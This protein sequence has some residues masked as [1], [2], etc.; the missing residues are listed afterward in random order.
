[1]RLNRRF[2]AVILT[3]C[4]V[5][6]LSLP[7]SAALEATYGE[8]SYYDIATTTYSR[9]LMFQNGVVPAADENKL[10]GLIDVTGK[11]VVPF[12]YAGMWS[13]G[14]GYFK[15]SDTGYNWGGNQ[16]IIDS[17]GKVVRAMSEC[18]IYTN[19]DTI[20]IDSG[21]WQNRKH[22]CF[23]FS[24]NP[25]AHNEAQESSSVPSALAGYDY[26][27][28]SGKYYFVTNYTDG[29]SQS[30]LLDA[31]YNVVF[32][33]GQYTYVDVITTSE[34]T[35]F[36]AGTEN[37]KTLLNEQKETIIAAG[38]YDSMERNRYSDD[39]LAV[40]S[41]DKVGAISITGKVL[42]PLGEYD[43]ITG[44]NKDGYI[45]AVSYDGSPWGGELTNIVSKVFKDG[46]EVKTFDG[47]RVAT[48]VY[49]RD[50][51]FSTT[52]E[53]NG[54]MDMNGKVILE[55]KYASIVG[56]YENGAYTGDLITRLDDEENWRYVYGMYTAD[57]K[58]I[59]AD[60]YTE[61][62]HLTDGKYRL[63]DGEHY[64]IMSKS[65]ATVIPFNYVDMRVHTLY[66]I[67]LYDG[68][69]Y[70]IVDV[71]NNTIIG[72]SSEEIDLFKSEAYYSL[73]DAL[74]QARREAPEYDGYSENVYPFCYKTAEGYKTAYIDYTT[75][76]SEGEVAHRASNINGD[77]YFAYRADNGLYG[78]AKLGGSAEPVKPVDP[79][80]KPPVSDSTAY[81]STQNVSIDG[82]AV[83][84]QA[85]ALRDANG[86][87]TNYVKLRDV[88]KVLNGSAAQ[89]EVSWDGAVNIVTG[90]S[91]TANGS[92]M[93]TPF[94]GDRSYTIPT[95]VTKING[96]AVDLAAI[97]LTDDNGGGYT[98][99]QLRDLGRALSF[100]VGWSAERGIFV[101][102]GKPYTDAD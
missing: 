63:N 37:G 71:N 90:R 89:F 99:Y 52:G 7:A 61:L 86:N 18:S 4:M 55:E 12:Q 16:G 5:M 69:Y 97:V 42:V 23:D 65:G 6:N 92:E 54:M 31:N 58:Q 43:E 84:L 80:P 102:S 38:T 68:S 35:V 64:G 22:E 79:T 72:A 27:W 44:M 81:A 50:L 28:R 60:K 10:Y 41:G 78:I 17:T 94:S 75:G 26:Y 2:F 32:P 101:E 45:A 39:F 21:S 20:C 87:P 8:A 15:V 76:K 11:V 47:K 57:G 14:G 13:L 9:M 34:G 56:A 49:Y 95:A 19:G 67:E 88:A 98:Y 73:G 53:L 85:Y 30:G 40:T 24:M 96:E 77:G 25:V 100:N 33:L 91:Y 66:F 46:A 62:Y 3:L 82:T 48:E 29:G 51:A 59:F 70:S 1:M 74:D 36:L 93:F 83:E